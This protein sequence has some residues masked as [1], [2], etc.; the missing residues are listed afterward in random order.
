MGT[1]ADEA[2]ESDEIDVD[3]IVDIRGTNESSTGRHC[4]ECEY[5]A[6]HRQGQT[7]DCGILTS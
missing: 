7:M 6:L 5:Y 1:H 2:K 3:T 4:A